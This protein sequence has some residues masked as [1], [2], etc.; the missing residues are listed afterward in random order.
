MTTQDSLDRFWRGGKFMVAKKFRRSAAAACGAAV[1]LALPLLSAPAANA[2]VAPKIDIAVSGKPTT[3]S[4]DTVPTGCGVRLEATV[5]LPDSSP[6]ETGTVQFF[7]RVPDNGDVFLG[8]VPVQYGMASLTWT[9]STVGANGLS[10]AYSDGLPDLLPVSAGT[11]VTVR[12]GLQLGG[13]CL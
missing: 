13:L 7:N 5:T 2:A 8:K 4:G 9:A 12:P 6:V 11:Q 1:L 3:A 10:A